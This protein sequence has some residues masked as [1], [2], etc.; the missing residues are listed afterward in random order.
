MKGSGTEGWSGEVERGMTGSAGCEGNE[1]PGSSFHEGARGG[2]GRRGEEEVNVNNL[3]R[4][5][6]D[7]VRGKQM[8]ILVVDYVEVEVV[9]TLFPSL[10]LPPPSTSNHLISTHHIP[11]TLK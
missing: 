3:P 4:L 7:D 1:N 5:T 6:R 2:G 8:N 10:W 9:V 11:T